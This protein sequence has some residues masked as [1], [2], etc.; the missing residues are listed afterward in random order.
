MNVI[1]RIMYLLV[2]ATMTALWYKAQSTTEL[3]CLEKGKSN[4]FEIFSEK[5]EKV[6]CNIKYDENSGSVVLDNCGV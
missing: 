4:K 6:S 2:I 5:G 3:F 1:E